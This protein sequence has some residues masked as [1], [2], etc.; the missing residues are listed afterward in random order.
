MSLF[1]SCLC[2]EVKRQ[3]RLTVYVTESPNSF[4]NH[5]FG[6]CLSYS[7]LIVL[8]FV[9]TIDMDTVR[10]SGVGVKHLP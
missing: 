3:L 10:T 6:F 5:G 7:H 1:T 4:I 9:S 8:H 2:G